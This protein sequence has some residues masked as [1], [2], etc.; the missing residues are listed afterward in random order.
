MDIGISIVILLALMEIQIVLILA[1]V[2]SFRRE[3]KKS[4]MEETS[5]RK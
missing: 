4:T 3:W 2:A 5:K 1:E